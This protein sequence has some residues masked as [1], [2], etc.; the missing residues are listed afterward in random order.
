MKILT[1]KQEICTGCRACELA[2]SQAYFRTD[3]RLKSSIRINNNFNTFHAIMCTQCGECIN[4][5]RPT[6]LPRQKRRGAHQKM[7]SCLVRRFCS[8]LSDVYSD[9]D[10]CRSKHSAAICG[11]PAPSAL[12]IW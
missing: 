5:A 12:E 4:I 8:E 3:N 1:H 7:R 2:C 10:P 11:K 6:H 9:D